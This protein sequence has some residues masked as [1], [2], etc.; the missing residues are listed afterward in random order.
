MIHESICIAVGAV[1]AAGIRKGKV[2]EQKLIRLYVIIDTILL[3]EWSKATIL[4]GNSWT[5]AHVVPG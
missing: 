3:R 5:L 1:L 4:G 2:N